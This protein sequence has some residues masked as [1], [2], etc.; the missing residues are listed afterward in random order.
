M[1]GQHRKTPRLA[2]VF[3]LIFQHRMVFSK[4]SCVQMTDIHAPTL[5]DP[6]LTSLLICLTSPHCL[7][8]RFVLVE[9]WGKKKKKKLFLHLQ[10][11]FWSVYVQQVL[12]SSFYWVTISPLTP[13]WVSS[14]VFA[15]RLEGCRFD[16]RAGQTS[17]CL[18][19]GRSALQ[20][21]IWRLNY[22][23]SPPFHLKCDGQIQHSSGLWPLGLLT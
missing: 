19:A 18:L 22:H 2:P 10:A 17:N 15:L 6:V 21:W 9:C 4:V 3:P 7:L 8:W 11:V 12:H 20:G 13:F 23:F 5:F 1:L 16:P 14:T